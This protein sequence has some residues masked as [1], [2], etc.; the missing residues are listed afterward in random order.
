MF[1]RDSTTSA[2]EEELVYISL[3]NLLVQPENVPSHYV[4]VVGYLNGDENVAHLYLTQ[5]HAELVDT[6][7]AIRVLRSR[8]SGPLGRCFNR[9][10]QVVGHYDSG[11]SLG[12]RTITAE[13]IYVPSPIG[14][15]E[16]ECFRATQP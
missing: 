15:P 10:V 6:V 4:A 2:E 14:G 7:S 12:E 11:L 3:V 5:G 13:S 8:S 1:T 9:Y 16:L